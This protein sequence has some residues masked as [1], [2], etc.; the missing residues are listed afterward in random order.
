MDP[1]A[2]TDWCGKSRP[3]PGFEPRTVQPVASHTDY[4]T[5]AP[6]PLSENFLTSCITSY[7]YFNFGVRHPVVMS[8]NYTNREDGQSQR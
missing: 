8:G 1:R 7:L 3:P 4:T 2:D 5:P 6:K